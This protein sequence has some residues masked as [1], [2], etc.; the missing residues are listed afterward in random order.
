V[1]NQ[2][3]FHGRVW[4]STQGGYNA[5]QGVL[6]PQGRVQQG[7]RDIL[8]Q[9]GLWNSSDL[10]GSEAARL[11]LPPEP[12]LDRRAWEI[13]RQVW[14]QQ[15]WHVLPVMAAKLGYFWLSTDQLFWTRE[16]SAKIRFTRA[17]GVFLYWS[18][19]GLMLAGFTRLR[20][21]QPDAATLLLGYA[22]LISLAHLPF[23]MT[24]RHRIPFAEPL[25]VVVGGAGLTLL[26][27]KHASAL[28]AGQ[29][30]QVEPALIES[31]NT[32]AISSRHLPAERAGFKAVGAKLAWEAL[33]LFWII[34]VNVLYYAQYKA[35]LAV[36]F[37]HLFH[38]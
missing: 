26:G 3:V 32:G 1:R 20:R 9:A 10:D 13:A 33:F 21:Q 18:L 37:V 34:V 17:A 23:I 5:V 27:K 24:A 36:R 25:L 8:R 16:F 30:E 35:L 6:T 15:N 14:R 22:M 31:L 11:R 12:E 28:F 7:D 4:F 38:R 29:P 2:A 19:L